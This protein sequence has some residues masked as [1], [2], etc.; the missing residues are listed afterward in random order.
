MNSRK[1]LRMMIGLSW[2]DFMNVSI[3]FGVLQIMSVLAVARCTANTVVQIY[4]K[5]SHPNKCIFIFRCNCK[6]KGSSLYE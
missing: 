2:S 4:K 1:A 3:V 6:G 5:L